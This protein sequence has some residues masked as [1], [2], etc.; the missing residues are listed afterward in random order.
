[1]SKS[2][3]GFIESPK[4]SKK[5]P[6][7]LLVIVITLLVIAIMVL[8]GLYVVGEKYYK[9]H[10]LKGTVIN[11]INVSGMTIQELNEQIR[12]Y[13]LTIVER[14][15]DGT[16]VEEIITGD[17]IDLH[18]SSVNLLDEILQSQRKGKWITSNGQN[19][20][21]DH[22]VDYDETVWK[23]CMSYLKCFSEDFEQAPTNAYI[24]DY[25]EELKSYEIVP[26]TQGNQLKRDK[27]ITL[28]SD[29]VRLLKTIVNL[30]ENNCYVE[31]TVYSDDERLN[32]LVQKLNHYVN[33]T[34]TYTF[35]DQ[36][37]ILDG[38]LIN[39]WI[40]LNE[41]DSIVLDTT[42]V[43]EYVA[44]LRK[45]Y[46]TIF[47][48]RTFMTSYEQEIRIEEG[49]YGWWMNYK[50][51]SVELAAM[52]E[53]GESGERTPIYYQTAAQYGKKDYG[54]TYI[55]INLTAQHLFYY[56]NG[57]LILETDFVSGNPSKGNATEAGVYGITY[58]QR[59][60]TLVGEDYETPVSY[61]MPFNGHVGLHDATW[62]YTFGDNIYKSSGSHGC[63]NLPYKVAQQLY[64]YIS[65][66]T[67]VICYY[68]PGTESNS[69][70]TQS[71]ED[72]AL[73]VMERINEIG[74]VTKDSEKAIVRARVVYEELSAAEKLLVT[75]YDILLAAET[76]YEELT[77]IKLFEDKS[78][79]VD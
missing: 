17:E 70:T 64:Q 25:N 59:N 75:N 9:T 2:N 21:I 5:G 46:D 20:E 66:G 11:D 61:W 23:Q 27:V 8:V 10:F 55:E 29:A 3:Y 36:V 56:E 62:R 19:Y 22:F 43:D 33:V 30:E 14:A 26:E 39:Q 49:D 65:K 28:L 42:Y 52:I 74:R 13:E 60:D 32:S 69:I 45:K 16:Y 40:S 67:P 78:T 63:V 31:P 79:K 54:D 12:R 53:A 15:A 77:D 1:M 7:I 41:D 68:L 24:A 47:R 58:K 38:N 72:I 57:E 44:S 50:Q 18:L 37:E 35:D 6:K 73:S 34:I 51:E 48:P 4:G 71:K 76:R